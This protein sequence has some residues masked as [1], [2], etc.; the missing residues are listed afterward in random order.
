MS[1]IDILKL[2]PFSLS[3]TDLNWVA[4]K[5]SGMDE[6]D[7]LRQLFILISRGT[8][9]AD[10]EAIK[11]F[12]PAG[13]TRFFGDDPEAEIRVLSALTKGHDVPFLIT[14]DLEGSQMSLPF[15]MMVPN[16]L[17]LAANNDP[18]LTK[19][20]ARIASR[21]ARAVGVNWTFTPVL[22]INATFR[23]AITGTRSFGSSSEIIQAQSLAF[24]EELQDAG[25]AATVK[26]WPGEGHDDRDQHL[27]TTFIP[28]NVED[29]RESHGKLYSAAIE[30][31]VLSVMSAHIAFPDYARRIGGAEGREAFRPASLSPLLNQ[32]LLREE[33]GF[34]GLIVSDAT[35]MAGLGAWS[36]RDE[37]LP[38]LVQSGCDVI[39]FAD[40]PQADLER[41]KKAL[42]NDTLSSQRVEEAV[43]RI[44][45]LKARLGLHED[46]S[47]TV[48]TPPALNAEETVAI[49]Q[50]F[51][52]APTLVKDTQGV[53]PLNPQKHQRVLVYSTGIISPMPGPTPPFDL[54]DMLRQEG[55]EVTVFDPE[56][57]QSPLDY[58]L[59]IY[60]MGEET[61][62]TRGRIFFDWSGLAGGFFGAMRRYWHE[63]P[64][65]VISMGYPYYLYD[66]PEAPCLINAYASAKP[67]QQAVVDKLLGRS[68]FC[69]QSPIDPFCGLEQAR[70]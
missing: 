7:R 58:D 33:L 56:M 40:D 35:A 15:G 27:M 41:L 65:V 49:A 18:T 55:F 69:G 53:L 48:A 60:L 44:L 3:D 51:A 17:A 11:A 32:Q 29:W 39:L 67:M 52:G 26:H 4:T 6:E 38:E 16:A 36:S 23:S 22:D 24:I 28:L 64:T 5:L 68:G 10:I 43:V 1:A 61:L 9:E 62:L 8:D 50:S 54:P 20:V 63:R 14:A 31:G 45:G 19:E 34:N 70:Y 46:G 2:P 57:M 12:R 42:K 25:V 66:I 30:A 13:A 59:V 21:E 37:H 47:T